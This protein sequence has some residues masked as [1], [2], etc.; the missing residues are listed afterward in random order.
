MTISQIGKTMNCV[1]CNKDLFNDY[2]YVGC[3]TVPG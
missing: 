1:V 3:W 2:I